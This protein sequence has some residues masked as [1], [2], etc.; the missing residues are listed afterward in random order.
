MAKT[1]GFQHPKTH[2]REAN[3]PPARP[4]HRAPNQ[5]TSEFVVADDGSIVVVTRR[6]NH[7]G[8]RGATLQLIL[9]T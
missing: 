8:R 7:G 9:D 3:V 5:V 6:E 1:S 4:R 2:S